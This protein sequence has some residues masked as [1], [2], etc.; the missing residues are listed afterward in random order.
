M[1][2]L[3]P[4]CF[5][6]GLAFGYLQTGFAQQ[7]DTTTLEFRTNRWSEQL[8]KDLSL[9][10]DKLKDF[11]TIHLDYAQQ[12]QQMRKNEAINIE[13]KRNKFRGLLLAQRTEIEQLLSD[14]QYELYVTKAGNWYR[15]VSVGE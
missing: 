10:A 3:L 2:N 7:A 12:I 13:E 14:E 9:T 11:K 4:L 5:V 8:A 15:K 6:L 1:R